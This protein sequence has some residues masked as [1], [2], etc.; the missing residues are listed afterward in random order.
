MAGMWAIILD[1]GICP[2]QHH[3]GVLVIGINPTSP[4]PKTTVLSKARGELSLAKTFFQN[5]LIY[6]D[7]VVLSCCGFQPGRQKHLGIPGGRDSLV[8]GGGCSSFGWSMPTR[9]ADAPLCRR[10]GGGWYRQD[11]RC[12]H[13]ACGRLCGLVSARFVCG[14]ED[15]DIHGAIVVV[16]NADG[17]AADG[18]AFLAHNM[19]LF[20]DD[21]WTSELV[22]FPSDRRPLQ[23]H[24]HFRS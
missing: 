8:L 7:R 10:A 3:R 16:L 17:K 22:G 21:Q 6:R 23:G 15:R 13:A 2:Q 9:Y 19:V 1:W 12:G 20:D 4:V 18:K 5:R 14:Q 11:L 24:V